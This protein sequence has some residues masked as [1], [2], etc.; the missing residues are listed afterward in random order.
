LAVIA[1]LAAGSW[2]I[3]GQP[4]AALAKHPH[5]SRFAGSPGAA[6]PGLWVFR[7]EL[8]RGRPTI[9][10]KAWKLGMKITTK[11]AN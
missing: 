3:C 7:G 5:L 6:F 10:Y 4:P 2:V 1:P 8:R 9:I 11:R